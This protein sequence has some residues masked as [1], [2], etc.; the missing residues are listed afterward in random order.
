MSKKSKKPLFKA[1]LPEPRWT[2]FERREPT[3]G[4]LS[5]GAELYVNSRYHVIVYL[6]DTLLGTVTHL[7]I[8]RNDRQPLKDWRDFQ[9]I[10][11][12]LCGPEREA[13]EIYPAE[14]RLVDTSNQY[15]LWVLP[16]G[17]S[18]PFG[19]VDRLV[20]EVESDGT[21]PT[22]Q[23]SFE[24]KPEDLVDKNELQKRIDGL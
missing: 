13:V 18:V 2:P 20:T 10:K 21:R 7:S 8:R 3:N 22:K 12:E 16:E 15:H 9:Q 5:E 6:R 1:V 19:F 11:N 24:R 4:N 17:M 23:R 14:S